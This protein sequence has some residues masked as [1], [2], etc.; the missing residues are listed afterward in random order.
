[1]EVFQF[2]F[3]GLFTRSAVLCYGQSSKWPL[4]E[5]DEALHEALTG[6]HLHAGTR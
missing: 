6:E 1:M 3:D 2:N 5:K 4:P